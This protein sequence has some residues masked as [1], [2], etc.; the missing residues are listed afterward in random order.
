MKKRFFV[1]LLPAAICLAASLSLSGYATSAIKIETQDSLTLTLVNASNQTIYFSDN[2]ST[3]NRNSYDFHLNKLILK[4]GQT[5]RFRAKA[6]VYKGYLQGLGGTIFLHTKSD[7][8]NIA[9]VIG[10]SA[11]GETLTPII[12]LPKQDNAS[13]SSHLSDVTNKNDPRAYD[14]SIKTATVTITP[15]TIH[16]PS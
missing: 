11:I 13:L 1:K 2:M 14:I 16:P 10:D 4:P 6:L 12:G 7:P 5:D 9:F 15:E 3:H 8:N